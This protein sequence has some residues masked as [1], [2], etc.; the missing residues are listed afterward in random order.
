[1]LCVSCQH[2]NRPAARF[3]EACGAAVSGRSDAQPHAYTPAHLAQKILTTRAALEG[4]RKQVTVFFCDLADSTQLAQRLGPERM[5]DTLNAFFDLALA[6]V[7]RLEGTI[8]QFL[9]DGFMALFGAPLAHEDHVRRA[10]LCALAIQHRLLDAAASDKHMLKGVVVRMGLNTG[11]VVVGRIGDNLRMDYTAIGDTTNVAARLQA[12]A[13]PGSTCV[14]ASVQSIGQ[15]F[16]EFRSLGLKALKGIAEPVDTFELVRAHSTQA[17]DLTARSL[18]VSAPMVGRAPELA[19]AAEAVAQLSRGLG[20]VLVISGEPGSGKSRLAAEWRRQPGSETVRWLEGRGLSFGRSL[21]YWPFIEILKNLFDIGDD[22]A[23]EL[24]WRKLQDGLRAVLGAQGAD[25]LPY[26]ATVLAL[27]LDAELQERVKYLDGPGLKRQVFL[28]MRQLFERLAER[29]PLLLLLEDWHW[30]DQSSIELADHLLPLSQELALLVCM[31]SRLEPVDT[32]GHVRALAAQLTQ[33]PPQFIALHALSASDSESLLSKLVGA[34]ALPAELRAQILHRTEGN[35]LFLEEVVRSLVSQ[36]VLVRS[37]GNAQWQLG[38]PVSQIKIP[39]TLQGLISARIDRL[40]EEAK[41]ALKLA[42]VIGRSFYDRVLAAISDARDARDMLQQQL[43]ALEHAELIRGKALLPE[44][45]HIFKHALVQEAAYGS[46]LV[47]NRRAIHRRVAKA[48]EALFPDRLDEFSSLLAHHF[49]LAED[50]GPAQNYLFKAGD[51]AGRMA[52][53]TEALEHLRRAETA[54]LKAHGDKLQPMQR[55]VLSRKVGAALYGTGQYEPAHEQF[56]NA[57]AQL[58]VV[59]PST[60]NGVLAA[61]LR[62][63][64]VHIW[65]AWRRKL[66][67][68]AA[69][70]LDLAVAAE[71]SSIAHMMAWMDYFLDKERML[72]DSLLELSAG[73]NSEHSLGEARG[74]STVGFALMT[75]GARRL[76]RRYH[77]R[78]LQLA[79]RSGNVSAIAFAWLALGVVD[80]WDGHW[81]DFETRMGHAERLF[82]ESGELHRWSSPAMQIAW[83]DISRGELEQAR[84]NMA[85]MVQL[86][87]DAADPLLC[88][89]GLQVLGHALTLQGPLDGAMAALVEGAEVAERI[90]SV[91]N[92]VHILALQANVLLLQG[93]VDDCEPLLVQARAI[94]KR[95]RMNRDFDQAELVTTEAR[96]QLAFAEAAQGP[97]R[98]AAL[99]KAL[100]ACKAGVTCARR[101]PLWLST[102]LRLQANAWWLQGQAAKAEA[103]WQ[104]GLAVANRFLFPIERGLCLMDR[105][106]RTGQPAEVQQAIELFNQTGARTYLRLARDRLQHMSDEAAPAAATAAA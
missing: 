6:E 36:G 105:G 19:Q 28:C 48:I 34:T 14:G 52:A 59:Y 65:R 5:H 70:K 74:L 16:F 17:G 38:K 57:L 87:R 33:R 56:R 93:R 89:W 81:D 11:P 73:E 94:V 47:E 67:M 100:L 50:W 25:L 1:M 30:A 29:E 61:A 31:V 97:A 37:A 85:H 98:Q 60:R 71:I 75:F 18:G 44:P 8:N 96:V 53:D 102:N 40:D 45:E 91:D 77:K 84:A 82:R 13:R 46:I 42:S 12:V 90:H 76:A 7:H 51:Q 49:T 72:L 27:P 15:A 92:L 99:V 20:G 88:S 9:G 103:A 39:D 63:L 86:G 83:F 24:G 55:A 26:V 2:E 58:A 10:L 104:E 80:F 66:G 3:C 69:R 68:P 78:A 32:A 62:A 35:P 64:G 41:Q 4:E 23:D 95:E 43:V 106:V 79:E 101:M 54:Y 21:S 22:D